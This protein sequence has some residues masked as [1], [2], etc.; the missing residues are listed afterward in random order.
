MLLFL[1]LQYRY[2]SIWWKQKTTEMW[3]FKTFCTCDT[4]NY[5]SVW[6]DRV[7]HSVSMLLPV[8]LLP[9]FQCHYLCIHK[10]K[11]IRSSCFNKRLNE[12]DMP[13]R[14]LWVLCCF[15][16]LCSILLLQHHWSSYLRFWF[17][18]KKMKWNKTLQQLS[19]N[20]LLKSSVVRVVFDFRARLKMEMPMPS[21]TFVKFMK[22]WCQKNDSWLT[23]LMPE[24]FCKLAT[25][26]N[27][28]TRCIKVDVSVF[29]KIGKNKT[30]FMKH[31]F[32]SFSS[33][34]LTVEF[35][36]RKLIHPSNFKD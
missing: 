3:P 34:T 29:L 22:S 23:F 9:C 10:R 35:I 24:V 30:L 4:F 31:R 21:M 32:C 5:H 20:K 16:V 7:S 27:F 8:L 1:N 26:Q 13:N 17:W 19:W 15:W 2:L 36:K 14:V 25:R 11:M 33:W 28:P 18:K 6:S 12:R